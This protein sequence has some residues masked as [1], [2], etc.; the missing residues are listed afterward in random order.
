MA[1]Q[2]KDLVGGAGKDE[3]KGKGE[4]E[5]GDVAVS[6]DGIDALPGDADGLGEL[7]LRPTAGGSKFFDSI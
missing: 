5:T 1:L 6:L 3:G 4:F 7:L 2:L